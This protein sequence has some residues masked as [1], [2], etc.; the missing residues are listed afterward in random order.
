MLI[1][2]TVMIGI[3][4]RPCS[5][6]SNLYQSLSRHLTFHVRAANAD[7]LWNPEEQNFIIVIAPPWWLTWW[8]YVLYALLAGAAIWAFVNYRARALIMENVV[9]KI[10]SRCAP[11]SLR[12]PLKI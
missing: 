7:G 6:K 8:A 4:Y 12:N 5:S 3:G 11:A 1:N 10:K 2:W 9:L